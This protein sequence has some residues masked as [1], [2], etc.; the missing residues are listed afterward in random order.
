MNMKKSIALLASGILL[1]SA[2]FGQSFTTVLD[3]MYGEWLTRYNQVSDFR[4]NDS[5]T[6]GEAAKFVNQYAQIEGL[7]K[8][9]TQCQFSDI[10]GYDYTLVPHIAEACA[11]GLLKG[12]NGRYMP[13][14]P[15]TEAQA[16]TVI[17]RSLYGF[18][19]ETW[20][21]W[22][23]PYYEAGR[24]LGIIQGETLQGVNQ[25]NISRQKLGTRF[26]IASQQIT[27]ADLA[28]LDGGE[29]LRNILEEIFGTTL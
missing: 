10:E 2:V 24:V 19:D 9:Y 28:Q 8:T 16:I 4:P 5:I 20:A 11:Y 15:I 26:Y 12:S 29:D 25:V 17:I 23:Q 7:Q 27:N 3:W 14:G 13:N 21:Y 22:R 6:R 18:L 1:A